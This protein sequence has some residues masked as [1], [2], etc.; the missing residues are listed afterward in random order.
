MP[1]IKGCDRDAAE[2][3]LEQLNCP[4]VVVAPPAVCTF[5][6]D[7]KKYASTA[8]VGL[9]AEPFGKTCVTVM[10]LLPMQSNPWNVDAD[11][12]YASVSKVTYNEAER[13]LPAG[14]EA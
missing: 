14:V 8:N 1:G 5:V 13:V 11:E 10:G 3:P 12:V 2:L 7:T 6:V 4:I 9:A